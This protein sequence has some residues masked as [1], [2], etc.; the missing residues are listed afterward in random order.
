SATLSLLTPRPRGEDLIRLN[1]LL[2]QDAYPMELRTFGPDK[3]NHLAFSPDASL[4]L[5]LV[6]DGQ[7][8]I[9]A[10]AT[11]EI[12]ARFLKEVGTFDR[13]F[14]TSDAKYICAVNRNGKVCVWEKDSLKLLVSGAL[15]E[16]PIEDHGAY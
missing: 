14:F 7:I 3:L 13:A 10:V 2:L 8:V 1:R 16:K 9:W 15:N 4:I 11:G 5:T 12:K 6:E